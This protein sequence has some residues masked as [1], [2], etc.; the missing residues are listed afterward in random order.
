MVAAELKTR[1]SQI[2]LIKEHF[3]NFP[4]QNS[5]KIYP[6]LMYNYYNESNEM[7]TRD[8][9]NWSLFSLFKF[10]KCENDECFYAVS[11]YLRLNFNS[12]GYEDN[13]FYLEA[14]DLF[15]RL[16]N[17]KLDYKVNFYIY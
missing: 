8:R 15:D 11:I 10:D 14:V 13:S 6:Y 2:Q 12:L 4:F 9:K 5:D 17:I 3:L 16:K 7:G 1:T